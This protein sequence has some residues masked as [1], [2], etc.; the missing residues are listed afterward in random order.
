MA[1]EVIVHP[2]LG[3]IELNRSSRARSFTFRSNDDGLRCTMPVYA[4]LND[5]QQCIEKLMPRL[6]KLREKA[7]QKSIASFID[8]SFSIQADD[9]RMTVCEGDVRRPAARLQNGV[10]TITCPIGTKYDDEVLQQWMVKVAEESLRHVAKRLLPARLSELARKFGFSFSDVSIHKTHG[11][12]GSCSSKKKINLS[13]YL[14]MLPRHLQDYVMLH[15]L[16]HTR[17]MNHSD[18]FWAQMDAVTN[19]RSAALRA[20]MKKYDTSIFQKIP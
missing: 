9:F 20:E 19:N 12:W 5:L 13:L 7:R 3:N 15:E 16:C 11:R 18:R 10:L 2:V 1:K 17:E 8:T 14:M 4:T 6:L